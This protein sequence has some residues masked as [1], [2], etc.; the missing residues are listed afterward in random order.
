MTAPLIQVDNLC[1]RYGAVEALTDIS[2]AVMPGTITSL[3]GS[4]GAGKSTTLKAISGLVKPVSGSIRYITHDLLKL[5]A[6]S[7]SELGIAHVPEG[8]LVFASMT[9][10]ENLLLGAYI[11][12]DKRAIDRDIDELHELFP[13]LKT[14]AKQLA[15]TLSGGEQQMLAIGRALMSRPQCLILDEPTMGLAPQMI[16]RVLEAVASI[17]DK[18]I[19]V[20]MVEQNALEA[21]AI[22]DSAYV[23]RQGR[24]VYQG[25]GA[26][27][28]VDLLKQLYLGGGA[29]TPVTGVA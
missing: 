2:L 28:D 17:R 8:R 22:A 14:R 7:R 13:I 19:T 20:L 10:T 4:N 25:S 12:R 16:D 3:V 21:I 11:Q 9:V 1:V 27:L 18:G 24:L 5:R 23:L 26:S 15:G 6:E 29:A